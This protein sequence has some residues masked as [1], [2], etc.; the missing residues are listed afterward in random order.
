MITITSNC[1]KPFNY[2]ITL[3][4]EKSNWVYELD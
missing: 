3:G 4:Y 2:E 1:T